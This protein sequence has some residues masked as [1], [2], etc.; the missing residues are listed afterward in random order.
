MFRRHNARP[1]IK[2]VS[3]LVDKRS[4][5]QRK[6]ISLMLVPS[7][8]SGRT[9]SLRIPRMVFYFIVITIIA[10]A[11]VTTWF[12]LRSERF[13]GQYQS[14]REDLYDA[15][16][17]LAMFQALSEEERIRLMEESHQLYE[18]LTEEQHQARIEQNLLRQ[19]QQNALSDLQRQIDE[20]ENM[21]RDFDVQRQVIIEG[22][23]SRSIIPPVADLLNALSDSQAVLMSYSTL[24]GLSPYPFLA[25][26][27][28]DDNSEV[29]G[30]VAFGVDSA[31][32]ISAAALS[33]RI[34]M[35]MAEMEI[36]VLLIED[37]HSYR[38]RM[39]P[40]LRNFPTLWPISAEV[41]S[42]FGWRANPMGGGGGE[43]HSGIDLRSPTG[44]PIRAAGG[45]T[46]TF[47]GWRGGYGNTVMIDHG[48]GLVTLY[49]H[50]SANLVTVGQRVER[51]DIIAR[52]GT[53]GRTTGAHVHFEVI[54]NGT[55]INPRPFM[56]EHWSSYS[57]NR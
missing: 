32:P 6:Y 19:A 16:D 33:D 39:D 47:Q 43:F 20:L 36:Q 24:W 27:Y 8:S 40:H 18:Q 30:F 17:E 10:V 41:S 3:E 48:H 42:P 55:P 34:E 5:R 54:R 25:D 14:V 2:K 44:T 52:V 22:L 37:F 11:S 21:I 26:G 15:Q 45:G 50:N 4:H 1:P 23:S 46:V 57:S 38:Q 12:Y 49:A 35:L 31:A 13:A 56:M 7:Y 53:T 29:V 9:R 51:G 28:S